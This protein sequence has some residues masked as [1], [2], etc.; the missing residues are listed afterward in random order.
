[1]CIRDR[2]TPYYTEEEVK[3]LLR[4]YNKDLTDDSFR[5]IIREFSSE[6]I[7]RIG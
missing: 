6:A 3:T 1:M 5:D 2:Y 7:S 4:K